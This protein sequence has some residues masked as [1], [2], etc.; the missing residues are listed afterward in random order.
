MH[1]LSKPTI[2]ILSLILSVCIFFPKISSAKKYHSSMAENVI[3][4]IENSFVN[5]RRQLSVM[6]FNW[7]DKII[8]KLGLQMLA[9]SKVKGLEAETQSYYANVQPGEFPKDMN[10]RPIN[11]NRNIVAIAPSS[12]SSIW[13]NYIDLMTKSKVNS[14]ILVFAGCFGHFGSCIFGYLDEKV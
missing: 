9:V 7:E 13:S 2:A 3:N 14:A 11:L 6:S 1:S 5:P 10:G 12:N 8:Y 4:F